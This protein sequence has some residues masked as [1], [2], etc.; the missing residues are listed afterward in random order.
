[1]ALPVQTN[2]YIIEHIAFKEQEQEIMKASRLLEIE[3]IYHW[4]KPLKE[5]VFDSVRTFCATHR[6]SFGIRVFNSEAFWQD[7]ECLTQLPAFHI[8]YKDEYEKSFYCE[9]EVAIMIQE[10]LCEKKESKKSKSNWIGWP[11]ITWKWRKKNKVVSNTT[12]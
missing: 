8:Y 10:V 5:E 12:F 1:M 4:N 9:D 7:R 6:I 11:S 3:G 2:P